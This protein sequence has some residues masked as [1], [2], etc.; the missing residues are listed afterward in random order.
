MERRAFPQ[1][2]VTADVTEEL[3]SEVNVLF[4]VDAPPVESE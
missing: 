1:I 4:A 2:E 3:G